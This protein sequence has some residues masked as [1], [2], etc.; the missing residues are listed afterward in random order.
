[1]HSKAETLV[2]SQSISSLRIYQFQHS[3]CQPVDCPGPRDAQTVIK[4][5]FLLTSVFLG[6]ITE[7]IHCDGLEVM[8]K[9]AS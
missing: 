6:N 7:N 5:L 8:E 9:E 1:M 3:S 4:Q 2:S